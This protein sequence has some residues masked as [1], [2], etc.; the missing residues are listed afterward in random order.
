MTDTIV[1]P[2]TIAGKESTFIREDGVWRQLVEYTTAKG[3]YVRQM[4][5]VTAHT[6]ARIEAKLNGEA[7][8]KRKPSAKK[9]KAVA[10][11]DQA[12]HVA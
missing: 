7:L 1:L 8:P 3:T 5:K 10:V 2:G 4:R 11:A 6:L 12:Q 9:T